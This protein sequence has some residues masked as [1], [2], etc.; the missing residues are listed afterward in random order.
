MIATIL[1]SSTTFHA[2][3]Y[4]E[5]K[6][7]KGVAELFEMKNFGTIL[8]EDHTPEQLQ[9]YL[10]KYSAA[11][12]RI[13]N[14][15]FHV[16]ISCRGH[17]YSQEQL[18]DIA[19]Q[20]LHEMG[21]DDEGQPLLI[22][23]H[24]DTDNSHLHI[25]TSR[26]DPN[27]HKINHCHE[28][29]RSQEAIN[30]IID[31]DE[32][33]RAD[34]YLKEALDY[35]FESLTQ[36][37][38]IMQSSG[39]DCFEKEK[40]IHIVRGGRTWARLSKEDLVG[41]FQK[42]GNE[43]DGKRRRQLRAI[44][45]KYHNIASCRAELADMMKRKFGIDLV[46][47]GSKDKPYG[48]MLVDHHQRTVYQ[49]GTVLPVKHLHH[50]MS[51]EER[52]DRI[53]Q[54]VDA[55][56]DEHPQMITYELNR[57]LWRQY[58][59]RVSKGTFKLFNGKKVELSDTIKN[60]LRFNYMLRSVQSFSPQTE[61]ERMLLSAIWKIDDPSLIFLGNTK[62][63]CHA[64]I[65]DLQTIVDSMETTD[66]EDMLHKLNIGLFH[67]NDRHYCVDFRR[68]VVFCMEDEEL[69]FNFFH[70]LWFRDAFVKLPK[71]EISSQPL[72]QHT[73]I[74]RSLLGQHV[75]PFD[76]NA[77]WEVGGYDGEIDDERKLK[78]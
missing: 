78:R 56:L 35:R 48:Y 40:H 31:E 58:G 34:L 67:V 54:A 55:M 63:S 69:D 33:L 71:Q 45:R 26:V 32:Q 20:Y 7:A 75:S 17:E 18:L 77:E 25:V 23:A 61:N 74:V 11:N 72:S 19:H 64:T 62:K 16:A 46:F 65:T 5:R 12:E 53:E 66:V 1:P 2:V 13:R 14:T 9:K 36:F 21:Y 57:M 60:T 68:K 38:A 39:Y 3:E 37:R 28:R 70:T 41:L 30:K 51:D 10:T 6:V 4:N 76:R 22:Y 15:Q 44:L 24:H 50:F 73:S 59:T 52:I 42:V 47:F 8:R 43:K 49:G 29:I 27:G